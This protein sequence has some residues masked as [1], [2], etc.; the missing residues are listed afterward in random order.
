MPGLTTSHDTAVQSPVWDLLRAL[1][2]RYYI[3]LLALAAS[4]GAAVALVRTRPVIYKARA[5]VLI[6]PR[7]SRFAGAEGDT[8]SVGNYFFLRYE[9]QTQLLILRSRPVAER[10]VEKL[11]LME[12]GPVRTASDPVAA[13]MGLVS[14]EPV[15]E[16]RFIDVTCRHGD[17]EWAARIANAT[18]EAYIAETIAHR[19]RLIN[20]AIGAYSSRFPELHEK[21]EKAEAELLRFQEEELVV[22]SEKPEE[23]LR[24]QEA[25]LLQE[26]AQ[27]RRERV[28]AQARLMSY[29]A[30][31]DSGPQEGLARAVAADDPWVR[32]LLDARLAQSALVTELS[33][34]FSEGHPKLETARTRLEEIERELAQAASGY[35]ERLQKAYEAARWKEQEIARFLAEHRAE[36]ARMRSRLGRY[37]AL[38]QRRDSL[39]ALLDPLARGQAELD[40]AANLDLSNAT[41]WDLAT[42]PKSPSEPQAIRYLAV[43]VVVG[44][45]MGAWFAHLLD[46]LDET[47]RSPE[48]LTRAVPAPV[49]GMISDMGRAGAGEPA[50]AFEAGGA[51]AP[52]LAEQFRSLRTGVLSGRSA[53][54]DGRG[55]VIL[56]TSPGLGDGKTTIS[57]NAAEACAQLGSPVV[58]VD[59][60]M[61]RARLHTVMGVPRSP[62]LADV[63]EGGVS[64]D[65][66]LEATQA[67]GLFLLAAGSETSRPAELLASARM[68]ELLDELRS[69]FGLVWIDSPPVILVADARNLAPHADLVLMVVRSASTRR[70]AAARAWSL[71]GGSDGVR[72]ATVLNGVPQSVEKQSGYYYGRCKDYYKAR[73][74]SPRQPAEPASDDRKA[75][76]DS[77]PPDRA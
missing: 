64:L 37:E 28:A 48:D 12:G 7:R 13:V 18:A 50:R 20:E 23:T 74:A 54:K 30:G 70:R 22:S 11:K 9:M 10:V 59:A 33:K 75:A 38:R 40:L 26:L 21:L 42:P 44:L 34:S 35:H 4:V 56:V 31:E 16:T 17:P 47:V 73:P 63:L 3:V 58:L 2:R 57:L 51:V 19:R 68:R 39:K 71:L 24:Q 36:A 14:A 66:A 32:G 49:V 29:S 46:H 53:G 55:S 25:E 65:R 72:M 1:R 67:P 76:T 41:I 45:V 5:R 62:G 15:G 69:R 52:V 8:G 27:A 6:E 77:P 60:D 43:A 61:R